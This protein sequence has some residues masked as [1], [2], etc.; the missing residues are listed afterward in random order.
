MESLNDRFITFARIFVYCG[1]FPRLEQ[2]QL[3]RKLIEVNFF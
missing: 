1:A 2:G 3:I